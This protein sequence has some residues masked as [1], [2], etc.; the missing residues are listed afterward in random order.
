M[1]QGS[2]SSSA[3]VTA[4]TVSICTAVCKFERARRR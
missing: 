2:V 3:G 1:L 4:S